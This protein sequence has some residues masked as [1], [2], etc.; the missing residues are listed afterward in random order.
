M[1]LKFED[2]FK[3]NDL[4]LNNQLYNYLKSRHEEIQE[5]L[6]QLQSSV[7]NAA[8]LAR[9]FETAVT[10]LE[11]AISSTEQKSNELSQNIDCIDLKE[12]D[13]SATNLN[14]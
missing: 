10:E 5:N 2:S 13:L 3:W 12:S 8:G 6:S 11:T 9:S 7:E 1:I 4:G 14:A